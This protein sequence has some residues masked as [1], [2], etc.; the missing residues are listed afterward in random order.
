MIAVNIGRTFLDA[1]NEKFRKS[2]SAKD[3]FVEVYFELFFNHEK[4][5]QWMTNSPF[6]QGIKKGIPPQK[7]ER[8][9]KLQALMKKI[10]EGEQDASVAIGFPSLDVTASTSGQITGM[11]LPMAEEEVYLSWIGSGLGIGVQGGLSMF[12]DNRQILLDLFEGWEY[13]REWVNQT[14]QS[15]GNQINTWNGQWI[16]HR[17]N[18]QA[19]DENRPM[20]LFGW[21]PF[22]PAP[23]GDSME[24][25]TLPWTKVLLG[26]AYSFPDT[27]EVAYVY[28]LGQ[29]NTTIGFIP[30][31]LPKIKEPYE[32]YEKYFGK[33]NMEIVKTLFG[34]GIGLKKACQRGSVGVVALEPKGFRDCF[35]EGN[36][37]KYGGEKNKEK[38]INFNAYQIWLLAMLNNEQL[39]EQAQ[40]IA[41]I[42]SDYTRKDDKEKERA[43]TT[44][45][46]EMEAV[47]KAVNKQQFIDKLTGLV[48]QGQNVE[49]LDQIAE[50][51]HKMP[52]DNVPYFLTLIRFKYA[53]ENNK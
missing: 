15:R 41:K 13:Y 11:S 44:K 19:Y 21:D 12:F 33:E 45:S 29:T 28:S 16:A 47:I 53:V 25:T 49:Q 52:V 51:I 14:P 7:E 35:E 23:G 10:S 3:F 30:F 40:Q 37:P 32:L 18:R 8:Q 43:K 6:V 22:A 39:W 38:N 9:I 20:A 26:I 50:I 31:E 42:L 36:I 17:Y 46:R 48:N 27:E 1:Y 5:M 24:V 34:T 4:Y 2:Y